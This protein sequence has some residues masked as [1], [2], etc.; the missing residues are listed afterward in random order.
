MTIFPIMEPSVDVSH[1]ADAQSLQDAVT[2]ALRQGTKRNPEKCGN[3]VV[4]GVAASWDGAAEDERTAEYTSAVVQHAAIDMC[5]NAQDKVNAMVVR[6][7]IIISED[8][9]D[10]VMLSKLSKCI[11]PKAR[12]DAVGVPDLDQGVQPAWLSQ[13]DKDRIRCMPNLETKVSSEPIVVWLDTRNTSGEPVE[14]PLSVLTDLL[15]PNV[16]WAKKKKTT[17]LD[18]F[19]GHRWVYIVSTKQPD[20][21]DALNGKPKIMLRQLT[22]PPAEIQLDEA[23]GDL[24]RITNVPAGWLDRL[25]ESDLAELATKAVEETALVK[26][27]HTDDGRSSP[28]AWV[29]RVFRDSAT[30]VVVRVN[31]TNI[32]FMHVL[33]SCM[34]EPILVELIQGRLHSRWLAFQ[35]WIHEVKG[36][37]KLSAEGAVGGRWSVGKDRL[38]GVVDQVISET[39]RAKYRAQADQIR[40]D[41]QL[42]ARQYMAVLQQLNKLTSHQRLKVKE[43]LKGH[44]TVH[45]KGPAGSGKTFVALHVVVKSMDAWLQASTASEQKMRLLFVAPNPA[46]YGW[47]PCVSGGRGACRLWSCSAA[48]VHHA[49]FCGYPFSESG[50]SSSVGGCSGDLRRSTMEPLSYWEPSITLTAFILARA[51]RARTTATSFSG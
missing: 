19:Y 28:R 27:G 34:F 29:Q 10:T 26:L 6:Q 13:F 41:K 12:A 39:D 46:M 31:I 37:V 18:K 40:L 3:P 25:A 30:S 20:A 16:G 47:M 21:P 49:P 32:V 8:D 11:I 35:R 45:V 7:V 15:H 4:I 2:K 42:F 43:C 48:R 44:A 23:S 14:I 17:Q 50:A 38:A 51:R 1:H 9:S 36:A 24:L 5:E 22:E 33:R